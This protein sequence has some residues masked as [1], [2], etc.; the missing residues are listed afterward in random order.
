MSTKAIFTHTLSPNKTHALPAWLLANPVKRGATLY[1]AALITLSAAL[2]HFVGIVEQPPQ[3]ASLVVLLVVGAILQ[4][5]VA[6]AAVAFPARRLLLIA[7]GIQG[8]SLL[9]WFVAHTFGIFDGF[10]LWRPETLGMTDL[11]LPMMEGISVGLFLCLFGKSWATTMQPSIRRAILARLPL[12]FILTL[13]VLALIEFRFAEL[14]LVVFLLDAQLPTSLQYFF[15]PT[16]GVIIV[17]LLLRLVIPRLRVRTKGAWRI[18]LILLPTFLVVNILAWDGIVSASSTAWLA[19]SSFIRAPL[20]QTTTLTYCHS[21]TNNAPLAMDISEPSAQAARPA[22][23]V[24]YI[25]GGETLQGSRILQ[26][27]SLDG[28]YFTQLRNELVNRGFVVGSI[29]YGLSP[30]YKVSEEVKDAKCA[31]RFLREYASQLGIDTQRIGVY[32]PSQGGYIS[33]M[34]GTVGPDAGYDVGQYLNQ[35]SRVQ[36]VVDMWGPTDLSN[37]SGSPSWAATFTQG[38]TPAGLRA[39]SPITYVAP[40][41]PPFL[42]IH[43][44]N[45]W[46]IAPHHSQDMAKRLKAANVPVTLI[47]VQHDQHGLATPV[48]GQVEQPSPEV[49]VQTIIDFFTRTLA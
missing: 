45:D 13:L 6:L 35:S 47:M 19:P 36:A 14:A 33:A 41:D 31:V 16:M 43:G 15:L 2:T 34:L 8:A 5:I 44:V 1:W 49:L 24:F 37:F 11:F 39:A 20:G 4:T 40:N 23:V 30:L 48:A 29:D 9:L 7:V 22:P 42:I 17:F 26:D 12:I 3:S 18:A 28:V 46:F 10:T 25:H 38:S 21:S 27:G 32:G